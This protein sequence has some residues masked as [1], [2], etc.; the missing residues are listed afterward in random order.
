MRASKH[1]W[2]MLL[3]C[4][5]PIVSMAALF[6]FGASLNSWALVGLVLLCPLSHLLLMRLLHRHA[7]EDEMQAGAAPDETQP[8]YLHAS[9]PDRTDE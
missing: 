2:L 7:H 8:V 4:L 6:I 5:L 1:L 3:C 9:H